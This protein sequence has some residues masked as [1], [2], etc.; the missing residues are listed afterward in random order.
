M[1]YLLNI[2]WVSANRGKMTN[3]VPNGNHNGNVKI[4]NGIL[5]I[6]KILSNNNNRYIL[7]TVF[8]ILFIAPYPGLKV[9]AFFRV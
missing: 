6:P 8:M 7:K 4:I 1:I 5:K 2:V 9:K 3:N